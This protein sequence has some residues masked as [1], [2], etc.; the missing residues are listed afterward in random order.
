[1]KDAYVL[2]QTFENIDF[3][4]LKKVNTKTVLSETVILNTQICQ[5]SVFQIAIL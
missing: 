2:D 3:L 5:D 1:M 4:I